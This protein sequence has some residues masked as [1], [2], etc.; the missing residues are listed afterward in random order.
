MNNFGVGSV[1]TKL[2]NSNLGYESS[3]PVSVVSRPATRPSKQPAKATAGQK[4]DVSSLNPNLDLQAWSG[5][6]AKDFSMDL[7]FLCSL[8]TLTLQSGQRGACIVDQ[9]RTRIME[10]YYFLSIL[11]HPCRFKTEILPFSNHQTIASDACNN[12]CVKIT[13]EIYIHSINMLYAKYLQVRE[14]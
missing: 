8:G 12:S 10:K 11:S 5:L 7:S 4:Q 1:R 9:R 6:T 3:F 14:S 13:I 2:V